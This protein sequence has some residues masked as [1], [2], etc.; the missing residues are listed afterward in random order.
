MTSRASVRQFFFV[1]RLQLSENNL[2]CNQAYLDTNKMSCR[3]NL[4]TRT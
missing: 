3:H 1:E 4:D 2:F